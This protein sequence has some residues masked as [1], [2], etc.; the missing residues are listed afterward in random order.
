MGV[1]SNNYDNNRYHNHC[2]LSDDIYREVGVYVDDSIC[3]RYTWVYIR[4]KAK[5]R[6]HV[7]VGG[8][9]AI[10]LD[11]HHHLGNK[12]LDGRACVMRQKEMSCTVQLSGQ[13]CPVGRTA[14]EHRYELY[15][16]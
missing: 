5:N 1:Y 14:T 16:L 4:L 15:I 12:Q 2:L 13:G 3:Y 11:C 7:C 10:Y 9:F 8:C 6:G